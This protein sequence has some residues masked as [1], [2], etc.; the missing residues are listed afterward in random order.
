MGSMKCS[1]RASSLLQRLRH[2]TS[3][4][5]AGRSSQELY[6]LADQQH[7]HNTKLPNV[8]WPCY[9]LCPTV[10]Q[11]ESYVRCFGECAMNQKG[12]DTLCLIP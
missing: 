9:G 10:P 12:P 2:A 8:K 3:G 1:I 11:Q 6:H 7:K 5:A 4:H